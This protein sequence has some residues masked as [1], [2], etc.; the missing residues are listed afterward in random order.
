MGE[1]DKHTDRQ[2]KREKERKMGS[3]KG[4]KKTKSP[5][6]GDEIT[7]F[8]IHLFVFFHIYSSIA[9]YNLNTIV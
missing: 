2:R 7:K 1:T 5:K 3:R 4:K 9:V 8:I 6:R